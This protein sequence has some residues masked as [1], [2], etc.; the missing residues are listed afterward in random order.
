MTKKFFLG[1]SILIFISACGGGGGSSS[2]SSSSSS[3]GSG[4]AAQGYQVPGSF[5]PVDSEG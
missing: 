5:Q 4:G 2:S 3:S 1:L